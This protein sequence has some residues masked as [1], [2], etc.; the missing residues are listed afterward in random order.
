M[1]VR[2]E[3]TSDMA[4]LA[5]GRRTFLAG[6]AGA[7]AAALI[8]ATA[9]GA[10][11]PA[12]NAL[13]PLALPPPISGAERLERLSKA[14]ALMARHGIGAI[15]VEP[16][17]SLDYFTGVQWWRSERLTAAVI[18]AAGEPIIVTPF[19]EKPSV[20]ESLKVPAE[21][22][23]WDE[24][25]E[26]LKL[27]ADFLKER[28]VAG[29][30]VGFE[31]TNRYFILDKLQQQ[32]PGLRV[33]SANPVV[34][35]LRMIKSPAEIAL[36]KAAADVTVAAFRAIHPR[37]GEGMTAGRVKEMF[38]EAV[39]ALGGA[40]G[41]G[42]VL[43]G[44][45]SALPHGTGKPQQLARGDVVLLDCG[46]EVHGYQ[47]DISRTYVFGADPTAEQRKVWEQMHR[48]QQ[49]AFAAAKVGVPAGSVDD[50]VRRAYESWGYGPGYRLP[51]LSHRTGHGIGMEGH[52]PINLV[53]GETTPLAPGMCFSD[54]PGLYLPGKFGVRLED[55]FHMSADGPR[56][57]S[58]PPPSIDDPFG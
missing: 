42:L 18:P 34:R 20:E 22:R 41:S 14:R 5:I 36:M 40:N 1:G 6:G 52:E 45:A 4:R 10:A 48:G 16:G 23:T 47:S 26:P 38:A 7:S 8:G 35:A 54:E 58:V 51:G 21:V 25:E 13:R 11:Q 33:V 46:C 29:S 37:I 2:T 17:A 43:F 31:E 19:F 49:I 24:H 9:P 44:P 27:V 28:G 53:H 15:I 55:C 12:A 57:F 39:G 50:A 3:G 30:P 56:W 32:L